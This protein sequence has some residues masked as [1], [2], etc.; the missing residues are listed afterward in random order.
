[1]GL[2][3][4]ECEDRIFGKA[5]RTRTTIRVRF[6][7]KIIGLGMGL[8]DFVKRLLQPQDEGM[9][10]SA[11]VPKKSETKPS[12]GGGLPVSE[13]A[14]R[15]KMSEDDL[16]RLEPKYHEFVI[17]K[18]SGGQRRIFAPTQDLKKVQ[19]RILR[20]ILS[21][22]KCHPAAKG[23][24]RG[25]SIVTNASPHVRQ[26]VVIRMD[27]K[28]YFQSTKAERIRNFFR[29]IGWDKEAARIL[30]NLCTHHGGL[31]PGAP[32]SPRLSNLVNYRLDTRLTAL[33]K[34]GKFPS[35]NPRTGSQVV[36]AIPAA[37][38]AKYTRYADD[39]TF[40]FADEHPGSIHRLI[41]F[42]KRI[43]KDE[44]Y[45]VHMRKKLQ[46]RRQHDQ[47][48]VT[49]LVVNDC[50]H[51]PRAVRRRLRAVEHHHRTGRPATL[52]PAQLAGWKALKDM[53]A[54]QT[55]Q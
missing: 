44:G 29:R 32:T 9:V 14:R 18:R 46:I 20:R 24:E 37:G 30:T 48:K 39:L 22:L 10:R 13:L 25:Q 52:T 42:V 15:L 6:S 34:G 27:L 47:Q 3:G 49:G 51:L 40:S 55:S 8:W 54:K 17:P 19:R 12:P 31:P 7:I 5:E 1:M 45:Q 23:F 21:R 2:L 36:Q 50:V 41:F 4:D 28:D 16:R 38:V 26:S 53:I 33:A 43:V 11:P 35:Y